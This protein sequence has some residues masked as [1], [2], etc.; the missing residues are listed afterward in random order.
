MHNIEENFVLCHTVTCPAVKVVFLQTQTASIEQCWT[1]WG[2]KS[3]IHPPQFIQTING[4]ATDSC[5]PFGAEGI[6]PVFSQIL[7]CA[8]LIN[9]IWQSLT[10]CSH[11]STLLTLKCTVYTVTCCLHYTT[12]CVHYNILLYNC[13]LGQGCKWLLFECIP[14]QSIQSIQYKV[15]NIYMVMYIYVH[16]AFSFMYA[17]SSVSVVSC[18]PKAAEVTTRYCNQMCIYRQI[19]C[20]T[21]IQSVSLCG[22]G[23]PIHWSFIHFIVTVDCYI[24]CLI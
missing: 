9:Q 21:G 10:H 24:G 2:E 17:C 7:Y 5:L 15:C 4:R 20:M 14:I 16:T 12:H 19:M 1:A 22:L 18:P 23:Y 3:V 11:N 8:L 6:I 13:F